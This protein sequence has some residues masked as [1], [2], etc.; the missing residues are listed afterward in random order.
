VRFMPDMVMVAVHHPREDVTNDPKICVR[1]LKDPLI[2][3][4]GKGFGDHTRLL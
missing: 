2:L 1:I 4:D 3:C